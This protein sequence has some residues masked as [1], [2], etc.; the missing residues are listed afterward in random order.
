VR[1]NEPAWSIALRGFSD[2]PAAVA[3]TARRKAEA[4]GV[5]MADV[6]AC[7]AKGADGTE[8]A[9]CAKLYLP[10]SDGPPSERPYGFVLQLSREDCELVWVFVAFGPRH[11]RRGVRSVYERAHR[12]L[13]G[14]FPDEGSS[15]PAT[16]PDRR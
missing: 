1:F 2:E 5:A 16:R 4:D 14:R 12:Q 15:A 13:H 3:L 6:H 10:I 11:P 8:L 7:D 9:G